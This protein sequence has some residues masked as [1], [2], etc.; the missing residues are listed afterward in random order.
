MD[1]GICSLTSLCTSLLVVYTN[2]Y[3]YT[4]ISVLP[5]LN[6]SKFGVTSSTVG[7]IIAYAILSLLSYRTYPLVGM[8]YGSVSG[9]LWV[10]GLTTFL[11]AKYWAHCYI[12]FIAFICALSYK[13]EYLSTRR[14]RRTAPGIDWLPW[15]EKVG[16]DENGSIRTEEV[17]SQ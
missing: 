5:L 15:I 4:S 8:V 11:A 13:V 14:V 17:E 12:A 1:R 16:W 7:F 9:L 3:P 10:N 2:Y 6:T